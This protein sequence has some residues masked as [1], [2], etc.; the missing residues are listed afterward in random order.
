MSTSS[1]RFDRITHNKIY[2]HNEMCCTSTDIIMNKILQRKGKKMKKK[3]EMKRFAIRTGTLADVGITSTWII[4]LCT[5]AHVIAK[6]LWANGQCARR[7]RKTMSNQKNSALW[8]RSWWSLVFAQ[9]PLATN[10]TESIELGDRRRRQRMNQRNSNSRKR[11]CIPP[12]QW[13]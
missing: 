8:L 3:I 6:F 11:K 1:V 12:G 13:K 10:K 9:C 2:L 7:T 5:R 4:L